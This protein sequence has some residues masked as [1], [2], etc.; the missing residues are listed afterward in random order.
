M[1]ETP[2]NEAAASGVLTGEKKAV[3]ATVTR[4]AGDASLFTYTVSVDMMAVFLLVAGLITRMAVLSLPK[5][6]VFDEMHYGRYA[7]LYLKGVFFFDSNPPLGKLLIAFMAKMAGFDGEFEFE[8]IGVPYP[9]NVPVFAMRLL[10]ALCGSLLMPTVYLILCELGLSP[11][12]GAL[13]GVLVLLGIH[14]FKLVARKR[15]FYLT[16]I[17]DNAVLAQSR[18]ILLESI[19]I[20]FSLLAV[21]CVLRFRRYQS[22]PFS[23]P[24]CFWIV[25]A[26]TTM[27]CA[28]W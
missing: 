5:N 17:S 2:P 3:V 7:S 20:L 11:W 24:W 19:M 1:P 15:Y 18:Y 13:A 25:A 21:F 23:K 28:L 16:Y 22:T 26:A 10:P 9:D 4:R 14:G 6:V 12:A 8:K 27:G